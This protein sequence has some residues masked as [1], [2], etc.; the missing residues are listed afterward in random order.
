MITT[1]KVHKENILIGL[2][3][4]N[5]TEVIEEMAAV[6]YQNGYISDLATFINDV[7]IREEHMTTGIGK[8]LAIP[9]GKSDAVVHST[10]GCPSRYS[11]I[12]KCV[13]GEKGAA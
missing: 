3:A 11:S 4:K 1:N 10:V 2:E 8:G 12:C 6:L 7:F 9:H 5:K 13:K